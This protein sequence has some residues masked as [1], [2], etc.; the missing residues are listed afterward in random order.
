MLRID[1]PFWYF[2][3]GLWSPW[4]FITEWGARLHLFTRY[5]DEDEPGDCEREVPGLLPRSWSDWADRRHSA[6]TERYLEHKHPEWFT[7]EEDTG[8]EEHQGK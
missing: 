5:E 7:D 3:A 4:C 6:A 1:G 2:E 8:R